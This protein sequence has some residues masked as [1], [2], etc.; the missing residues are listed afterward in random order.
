VAE[1]SSL[2]LLIS[3]DFHLQVSTVTAHYTTS[4]LPEPMSMKMTLGVQDKSV[5]S[6]NINICWKCAGLFC[7]G[8]CFIKISFCLFENK[9]SAIQK[10][11]C[12]L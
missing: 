10:R 12:D 2:K 11:V 4:I 1:A 9:F 8:F 3:S 5:K 6:K 7:W